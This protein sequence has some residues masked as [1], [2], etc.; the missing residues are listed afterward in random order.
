[1]IRIT[2]DCKICL[3]NNHGKP[4]AALVPARLPK[5]VYSGKQGTHS[6][7]YDANS[8][9]PLAAAIRATLGTKA[10]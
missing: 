2:C 8:P 4:L 3:N 10:G 9:S 7:V 6:I 5:S 1:M